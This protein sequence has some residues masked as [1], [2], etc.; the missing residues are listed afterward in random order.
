MPRFRDLAGLSVVITGAS[1]GIGAELARQLAGR[2]C[3]LTLA[4]RRIDALGAVERE[5]AERAAAGRSPS[6]YGS[7]ILQC[8]V[9]DQAQL[10]AL[11]DHAFASCG[12]VDVWVNNAGSG[13]RHRLL[14]ASDADMLAMHALHCLA[15]LHACQLL[16]PRWIA[17]GHP[18]QF[19]DV[20]S[21]G[22]R[23][24]YPYNAAYAA[25]KHSMSAVSDV[26][27]LELAPHGIT[28]TT[29]YPGVTTSDFGSASA[30][31]TGGLSQRYVEY[32]RRHANLLR[33]LVSSPQPTAYVAA[34]I[35]T[36]I[37]S[38]RAA[39]YPHRWGTLAAAAYTLFPGYISRRIGGHLPQLEQLDN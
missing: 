22:G 5:C 18:G 31:R 28:V 32:N 20:C 10:A 24:G 39:V 14:E 16:A 15:P 19:V 11:V 21:V 26:A 3:R 8:D 25:A 33:R 2:G 6:A 30:D 13:V 34:Q 29:V 4:A 27:R 37:A 35:V 17:A 12:G 1:A 23:V 36:A 38:R 9:T 7:T